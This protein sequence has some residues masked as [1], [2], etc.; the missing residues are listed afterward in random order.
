MISSSLTEVK[1]D[2]YGKALRNG[3][4]VFN[5]EELNEFAY[6]SLM[7][8]IKEIKIK[9]SL[10]HPE[11]V[12]DIP[13]NV[14]WVAFINN[15]K[16]IGFGAIALELA[17]TNRYGGISD[18]EQPYYYVANGPWIYFSRALNYSFGSNNTSRMI[19]AAKGSMYFEKTAF[20]PFIL[21]D[22]QPVKYS[23]LEKTDALL[24]HPIQVSYYL[25]TDNRNNTGWVVPIL[26]EPFDEGVDGAV[27]KKKRKN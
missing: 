15:N 18:A 23:M 21:K 4:I 22:S 9:S 13:Y 7:G 8:E 26:V 14:P 1:E 2:F 11:H 24:R 3:E 25:D 17:N 6:K 5:H 10:K 16:K 27:Q 20:I 12:V 19:R